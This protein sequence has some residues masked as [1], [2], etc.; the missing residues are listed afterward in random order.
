MPNIQTLSVLQNFSG[1]YLGGAPTSIDLSGAVAESVYVVDNGSSIVEYSYPKSGSKFSTKLTNLSLQVAYVKEPFGDVSLLLDASTCAACDTSTSP[2]QSVTIVSS[3]AA[4]VFVQLCDP[5]GKDEEL[6]FTSAVSICVDNAGVKTPWLTRERIVWDSIT[7]SE[8]TRV[9]EYSAD[10]ITWSTTAPTGTISL[11][12]C[13]VASVFSPLISEAYGNDLS[14]LL[15]GHNFSITKPACCKVKVTT[16]IG[17][18][19][20]VS[21]IQH[22]STSDF[23]STVSIISV[24]IVEGTCSLS[25]VHLIS[26]KIK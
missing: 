10:G 21:G 17:S 9:T 22:Y 19:T 16:S 24:E 4:P 14:T 18:F 5:S 6:I 1:A 26:N 7:Y 2:S 3:C 23:E 25:D 15:V 13:E 20:L 11:G 8:I 12:S